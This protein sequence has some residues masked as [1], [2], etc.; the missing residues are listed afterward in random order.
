MSDVFENKYVKSIKDI[1]GKMSLGEIT[2][3]QAWHKI[4]NLSIKWQ[5]KIDELNSKKRA[6]KKS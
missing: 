2:S 6:S 4:T 1:E 3:P 5:V